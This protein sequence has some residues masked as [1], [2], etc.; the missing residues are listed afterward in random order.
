M[1]QQQQQQQRGAGMNG[2]TAEQL[3]AVLAGTNGAVNNPNLQAQLTAIKSAMAQNPGLQLKLPPNRAMQ[4][5]G[6]SASNGNGQQ[7]QQSG[8]P[9]PNQQ[10]GYAS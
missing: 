6:G 10:Y 1:P 2:F 4:A 3:Q 9:N 8:S 7:R 5:S